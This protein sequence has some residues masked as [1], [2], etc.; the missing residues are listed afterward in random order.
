MLTIRFLFVALL[1]FADCAIRLFPSIPAPALLR[2]LRFARTQT[3]TAV[4]HVSAG[5]GLIKLDGKPISL[6]E[7]AM[8]RYKVY[9]PIL[10]VGTERFANIDI[11]LR[12]RGGGHV[13][14]VYALRQA[15]AKGVVA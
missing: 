13:S 9:E 1:A 11:R 12:V 3:A 2:S 7:P 4:A 15:I 10:T 6:I 8:L 14:Q 5:K